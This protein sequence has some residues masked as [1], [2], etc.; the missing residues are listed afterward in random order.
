MSIP[1]VY[2]EDLKKI[3]HDEIFKVLDLEE[4]KNVLNEKLIITLFE[5]LYKEEKITKKE[6]DLLV[7][8]TNRTFNL[9]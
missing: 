6:F 7:K 9:N 3:K 2:N 8:N 1:V 5:I 4:R